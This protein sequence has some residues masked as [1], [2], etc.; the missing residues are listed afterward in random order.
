MG[1]KHELKRIRTIGEEDPLLSV[2]KNPTVMCRKTWERY[3]R[4]KDRYNRY[5]R[6]HLKQPHESARY[7]A[8]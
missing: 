3:N 7:V 5:L 4:S 2:G 6:V 8:K 1:G